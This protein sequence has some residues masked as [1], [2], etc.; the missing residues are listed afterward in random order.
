MIKCTQPTARVQ[1]PPAKG[2]K[3]LFHVAFLR[4]EDMLSAASHR[5]EAQKS[6]ER[7]RCCKNRSGDTQ[8]EPLARGKACRGGVSGI[9]S[10]G[11][12]RMIPEKENGKNEKKCLTN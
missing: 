7:R 9:K 12:C 11:S 3:Y 2:Q 5:R 8:R 10:R 4:M 1:F 6:N